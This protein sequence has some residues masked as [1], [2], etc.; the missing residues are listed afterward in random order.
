MEMVER[1]LRE[2]E[3][4]DERT[5]EAMATVP[6][7]RFVPDRVRH[8]AYRDGALS[9]GE[10][11][12]ISQPWV[13]AATAQA[14]A[15]E[16]ADRVLDVGSGSGYSTAVLAQ[17]A[18]E[19]SVT[20]IERHARLAELGAAT[21][22]ELGIENA[23]ILVGDGSVPPE[24]S[25]EAIGVGAAAPGPPRRLLDALAP[26]GRLVCPVASADT[27]MLTRFT[28]TASGFDSAE[29]A[30]CRFVPL[31]GEEGFGDRGGRR[32]E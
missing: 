13:V 25:W 14:L 4:T 11:Q 31:V 32:M 27:D 1:Q 10:G 2:R 12:T 7:E 30:P 16:P 5:L 20:G 24:G 3:I 18:S 17:L 15:V 22:E 8:L 23:R 28:R 6:R 29:I 26:G 19:G 21:L 9:I